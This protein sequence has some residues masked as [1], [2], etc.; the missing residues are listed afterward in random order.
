M[1][2][3][4][5]AKL[6][7]GLDIHEGL[8]AQKYIDEI[9]RPHVKPHVGNHAFADTIVFMRGGA[10]HHT[11]RISADVLAMQYKYTVYPMEC[12]HILIALCYDMVM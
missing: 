12:A 4:V 5:S 2:G 10:K 8:I 6:Q 11:A 9:V 7:A 3:E 1:C